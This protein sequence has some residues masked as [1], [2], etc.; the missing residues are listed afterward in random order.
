MSLLSDLS[1]SRSLQTVKKLQCKLGEESLRE[2]HVS[3]LIC[4]ER[5]SLSH[6]A[7][8][9]MEFFS[10]SRTTKAYSILYVGLPR[11]IRIDID[12]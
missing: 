5:T 1:V 9:L 2:M 10:N 12:K 11:R 7:Y 6:S 4:L 3:S 8:S